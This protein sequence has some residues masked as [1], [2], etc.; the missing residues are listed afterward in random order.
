MLHGYKKQRRSVRCIVKLFLYL[1]LVFFRFRF[2]R[3]GSLR[4]RWRFGDGRYSRSLLSS[5]ARSSIP[6][7]KTL[8]AQSRGS[9]ASLLASQQVQESRGNFEEKKNENCIDHKMACNVLHST[10]V[11][12]SN[13]KILRLSLTMDS[14]PPTALGR[15]QLTNADP[16]LEIPEGFYDHGKGFYDPDLKHVVDYKDMKFLQTTGPDAQKWVKN[17]CR[18]GKTKS[19]SFSQQTHSCN[20]KKLWQR[21]AS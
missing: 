8:R 2:G 16:A 18:K 12:V 10:S 14:P 11:T 6:D 3:G 4:V 7:R 17:C 15:S 1:R 5:R 20:R 21:I 13:L 19:S 9:V